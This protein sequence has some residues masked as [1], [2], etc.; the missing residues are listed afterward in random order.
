[1]EALFQRVAASPAR[2]SFDVNHRPALWADGAAAPTLR[3]LAERADIVFVG[4]DE[5]NV[6]WGCRT[7]DDV[8]EILPSPAH[9]IVKD[10]DVGATEFG[11]EGRVFVPAL[12]IEVL[13]AVGAGDAFA[14]GYLAALLAGRGSA[15]RLAAGHER[16][17]LVLQSVSDFV[18]DAELELRRASNALSHAHAH[19][20][21]HIHTHTNPKGSV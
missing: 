7:A 16:A 12:T 3:A 13:E 4:L 1:M 15:E 2:L 19:T 5:A 21:T 11:D 14:A 18:A 20:P 8:R 17:C 9:L 10:G 6:L